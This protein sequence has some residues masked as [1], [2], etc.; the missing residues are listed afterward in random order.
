M[1]GQYSEE[2]SIGCFITV[3]PKINEYSSN[4]SRDIC[5]WITAYERGN[6]E[7]LTHA[8]VLLGLV[9]PLPTAGGG[10]GGVS[11]SINLVS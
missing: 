5:D 8:L 10:G 2:T 4:V 11:A 6:I 1:Q 7:V 3:W 9:Q